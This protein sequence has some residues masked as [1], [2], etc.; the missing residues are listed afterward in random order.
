MRRG[1]VEPSPRPLP[2]L[3]EGAT[4]AIVS[5]LQAGVN[6]AGPGWIEDTHRR[7]MRALDR[8]DGAAGHGRVARIAVVR[9]AVFAQMWQSLQI[10]P[11][12]A[13]ISAW[14]RSRF[15]RWIGS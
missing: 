11:M 15:L 4:A 7:R 2:Q 13:S 5:A 3:G 6:P 12:T 8:A 10:Q 9:L 14:S 1:P